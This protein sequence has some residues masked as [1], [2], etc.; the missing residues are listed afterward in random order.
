MSRPL[1]KQ[2]GWGYP[3]GGV[4]RDQVVDVATASTAFG[5]AHGDV[6]HRATQGSAV[7]DELPLGET[8]RHTSVSI[9][10]AVPIPASAFSMG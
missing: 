4:D 1:G 6:G 8:A 2:S 7:L 10:R 5:A 3:E 9:S